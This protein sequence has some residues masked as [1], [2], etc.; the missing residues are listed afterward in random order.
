MRRSSVLIVVLITALFVLRAAECGAICAVRESAPQTHCSHGSKAPGCT[1][2]H[3]ADENW[4]QAKKG[5]DAPAGMA[6]PAALPAATATLGF[7]A[8]PSIRA[9]P[10]GPPPVAAILRI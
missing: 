4:L 3:T 8:V 6:A 10:E 1:H 9:V 2:N 7:T 5:S